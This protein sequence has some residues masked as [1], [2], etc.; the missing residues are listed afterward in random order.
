MKTNTRLLAYFSAA[1]LLLQPAV[2]AAL[3]AADDAE[4]SVYSGT[5]NT[6]DN[7]GFGFLPWFSNSDINMFP[8]TGAWSLAGVRSFDYYGGGDSTQI[9]YRPLATAISSGSLS[10][11]VRFN[12]G[13]GSGFAGFALQSG[14]GGVYGASRLLRFGVDLSTLTRL[15]AVGDISQQLPLSFDA[16]LYT[17]DLNLAFD[18]TVD[19]YTLSAAVHG[20]S[21]LGSISGNLRDTGLPM[22][23]FGV[24]N[25]DGSNDRLTFD[26]I[27]VVPEPSTAFLLLSGVTLCLRRRSLRTHERNA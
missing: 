27:E 19:S 10:L 2:Q 1:A 7:G 6:G 26:S 13:G 17:L 25:Q 20:G 22:S 4:S 16:N 14:T 21:A 3:V 11:T 8:A 23:H 12:T 24:F 18:T 9:L 5:W 15:V